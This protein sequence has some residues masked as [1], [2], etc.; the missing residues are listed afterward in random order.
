MNWQRKRVDKKIYID[1]IALVFVLLQ[2]TMFAWALIAHPDYPTIGKMPIPI[3]IM[4]VDIAP[5]V[6]SFTWLPIR[7]AKDITRRFPFV[8]TWQFRIFFPLFVGV[9]VFFIEVVASIIWR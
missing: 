6:F 4:I 8:T 7:Y 5:C 2:P 9:V 3:F 1:L